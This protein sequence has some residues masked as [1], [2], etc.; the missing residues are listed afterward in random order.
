M[1]KVPANLD[2]ESADIELAA[3]LFVKSEQVY[4][5]V[6]RVSIVDSSEFRVVAIMAR[7][8]DRRGS[9]MRVSAFFRRIHCGR[10][11]TAE[12]DCDQCELC[13]F[14]I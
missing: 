6:K 2:T 7:D 4:A 5:L 8:A 9:M 10:T 12:K 11:T 3:N 13:Q 14:R 1:T